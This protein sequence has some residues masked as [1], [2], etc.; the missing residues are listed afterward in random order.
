MSTGQQLP[1]SAAQQVMP[2]HPSTAYPYTQ[3]LRADLLA[4]NHPSSGA[5]RPPPPPQTSA[6][7]PFGGM[8][9]SQ[10]ST[11]ALP[12]S[13]A[14]LNPLLGGGD[15]DWMRAATATTS[16]AAAGA[17]VSRSIAQPDTYAFMGQGTS[18]M[19]SQHQCQKHL[20]IISKHRQQLE[21]QQQQQQERQRQQQQASL[22]AAPAQSRARFLISPSVDNQTVPWRN[23]NQSDGA[24]TSQVPAIPATAVPVPA[25]SPAAFSAPASAGQNPSGIWSDSLVRASYRLFEAHPSDLPESV[26]SGLVTMLLDG[27]LP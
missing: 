20:A 6:A 4:P 13:N 3:V 15:L 26:L 14:S 9:P 17:P 12:P 23:I 11:M 16:A 25:L 1:K 10:R 5:W 8:E 2:E 24:G 18:E 22:P 19:A 7:A 27:S 21:Q